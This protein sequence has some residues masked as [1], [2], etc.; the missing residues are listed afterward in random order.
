MTELS[1]EILELDTYIEHWIETES[2][3]QIFLRY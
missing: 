1:T 2:A 3:W